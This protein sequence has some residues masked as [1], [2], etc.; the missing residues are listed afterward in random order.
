LIISSSPTG[1]EEIPS[2]AVFSNGLS[3]P[4][5]SIGVENESF[6]IEFS[7]TVGTGLL[8]ILAI[9]PKKKIIDNMDK[10]MEDKMNPTMDPKTILQNFLLPDSRFGPLSPF[11]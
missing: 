11:I 1:E 6:K 5:S 10:T 7:A 8:E 9:I 3:S 2:K 4:R